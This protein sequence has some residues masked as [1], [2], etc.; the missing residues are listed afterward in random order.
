MRK[1]A[2]VIKGWNLA[3]KVVNSCVTCKKAR[4]KKWQQIMSDLPPEQITPARPFVFTT[5][6]LFGPYEVKDEVRKKVRLKVWGIIFCCM[7]S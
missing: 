6:D 5:V 4:A 1:K 3:Q 2:W 7:A